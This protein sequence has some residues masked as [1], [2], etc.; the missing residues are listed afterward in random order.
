MTACQGLSMLFSLIVTLIGATSARAPTVCCALCF[1]ISYSQH[2]GLDHLLHARHW[3]GWCPC[4]DNGMSALQVPLPSPHSGICWAIRSEILPVLFQF[5]PPGG[6][7]TA[8]NGREPSQPHLPGEEVLP[9][10]LQLTW[11][12]NRNMSWIETASTLTEN[13]E[14]TYNQTIW[15]LVNL[16]TCIEDLLLTCR[17]TLTGS[18]WTL[19]T[20]LWRSLPTREVKVSP[21][22]SLCSIWPVLLNFYLFLNV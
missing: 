21:W 15:I 20:L 9:P 5:H 12:E 16:C 19:E 22:R 13:K 17:W 2:S 10:I 7:P 11:L 8:H 6:H 4:C 18:Q 14:G 3:S 1:V